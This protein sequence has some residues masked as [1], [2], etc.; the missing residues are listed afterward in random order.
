MKKMEEEIDP[1][2]GPATISE[3]NKTIAICTQSNHVNLKIIPD[4]CYTDGKTIFV[5]P[6]PP[7]IDPV[8]R[9]VLLEGNAIHESWHILFK[10]DFY[11]LKKFVEKY[12]KKYARKIPFIKYIAKDIVNIIE[13]GRIEY[14][15]KIRFLG[16][17]ETIVFTNS[18][19]LRKRPDTKKMPDWK[20]FM[21]FLL[22]LAVCKGIKERI[23]SIKI[24]SLL[25]ISR[26]YLEWARVQENSRCSFIAAEKIIDL[27]I[28][29]FDL[30][31]DYSQQVPSPPE[32][33][34]FNP[35]SDNVE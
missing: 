9:W 22:Q 1:L 26:F 16:N 2:I 32:S 35:K 27:M 10:S 28:Q 21:E 15:G 7:K 18:F 24:K 34:K 30:E 33:T 25:K 3:L 13:D 20:K 23:K 5:A 4:G 31:G 8:I 14:Q 29:Y 6:P 19:W 12:E 11:Y 17:V